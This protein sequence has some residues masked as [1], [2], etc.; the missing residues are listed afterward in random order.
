MSATLAA[1]ST[2]IFA[3]GD[4]LRAVDEDDAAA[5]NAIDPGLDPASFR[6]AVV[7]V[8]EARFGATGPGP[9]IRR[10]V[11]ALGGAG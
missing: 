9:R 11:L 1:I 3:A 4:D 5:F 7:S 6:A 2:A 10:L 8:L